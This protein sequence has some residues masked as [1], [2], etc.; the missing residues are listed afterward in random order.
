MRAALRWVK[1]LARLAARVKRRAPAAMPDSGAST[2]RH[3]PLAHPT[4]R[5]SWSLTMRYSSVMALLDSSRRAYHR[6][7]IATRL[8]AAQKATLIGLPLLPQP[9]PALAL[10]RQQDR[11]FMEALAQRR[12]ES[13]SQMRHAFEGAADES[14]VEVEWRAQQ[15]APLDVVQR[16]A[17][18]A[19]L[20]VAGQCDPGDGDS[21]VTEKFVESL[22]LSCGRPVLVVPYTGRFAS[23]GATVMLAWSGTRE[24]TRA[25]HDA[26]PILAQARAVHV[27]CAPHASGAGRE[28]EAPGE[29]AVD[30]LRRQGIEATLETLPGVTDQALGELLLSRGADLSVDLIVMGAYGHA[31]LREVVLGGVTQTM[32]AAMTVPVLFS[33]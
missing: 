2:G 19:D 26:V 16:E 10:R 7:E 31:R 8:A 14:P 27:V 33:H 15:G 12:A 20:I 32:L 25:M 17:C 4:H 23:T 28:R 3:R 1:P 5:P 29:H 30:Y 18:M 13:I 11:E 6:L 22:L 9:D 24:S 21:W